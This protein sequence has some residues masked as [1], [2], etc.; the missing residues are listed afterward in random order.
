MPDRTI[1]HYH[2][3]AGHYQTQYDSIAAQDV[4]ADWSKWLTEQSPGYALDVGAGSGRDAHW[5]VQQGWRVTAVEPARALRERGRLITGNRVR[6]V[7]TRL[8]ALEGLEKP[9]AGYDLVLLSAVWMHLEHAERPHAFLRL[10]ELL[11]ATGRLIITLRFGPSDPERPMYSVSVEEL[12]EF[13]HLHGLVASELSTTNSPDQLQRT[14][15]S[16]KTVCIQVAQEE[17]G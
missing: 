7:D 8:P 5:L 14:N 2:Q 3:Y 4:H 15:V 12:V 16:W 1:E 17:R 6:W 11:S 10:S 13:A 9:A